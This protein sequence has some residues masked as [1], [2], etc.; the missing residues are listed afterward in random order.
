LEHAHGETWVAV[1]RLQA[2]EPPDA[3]LAALEATQEELRQEVAELR[4][5][6]AGILD[7]V[8]RQHA[9]TRAAVRA[10]Q[11]MRELAEELGT[12]LE[13]L[14]SGTEAPETHVGTT[15]PS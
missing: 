10:Q 13:R 14:D 8:A 12:R 4:D 5:S 7:A 6:I 11:E 1:Q 15:A 2:V 3:R 9:T